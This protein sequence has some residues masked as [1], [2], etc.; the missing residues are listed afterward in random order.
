MGG[1]TFSISFTSTAMRYTCHDIWSNLNCDRSPDERQR[2]P[3]CS[4]QH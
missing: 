2:L 1:D 4:L 3:P